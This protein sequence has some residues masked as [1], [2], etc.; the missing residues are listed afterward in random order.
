MLHRWLS[1]SLA[2]VVVAVTG[3]ACGSTSPPVTS[4]S[5]LPSAPAARAIPTDPAQ[6]S[7]TDR[8]GFPEY[9][10]GVGDKLSLTLRDVQVVTEEVAVRPDGNISFRMLENVRAAGRTP[11]ELDDDL[12]SQL[13]RFVRAPK[14]DVEVIDY[15]SKI[16]SILGAI[17][18]L[19]RAPIKS[20]QGRYPLKGRTTVLDMI[21]EAGGTTPDA[22]LERVQLIR[23]EGS[24]RLDLRSVLSSG[25]QR[26]NV[27][28]QGG[29][30]LIVPGTSLRSKKVIVLGEVARPNVYMFSDDARLMEALSQAG[31]FAESALR[32]D[33]RLIRVVEGEARMYS[34]NVE[35]L[36]NHGDYRQNVALENDDILFVPRSFIG[37][38]NDVITKIEPLLNILLLPAT[39]RD[40][41]TTGGGLRLDTGDP[42]ASSS[43]FTRTLPGTAKPADDGEGREE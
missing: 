16:V 14:I 27:V 8:G 5:E 36:A 9:L 19:E 6:T 22:Q 43:N 4:V 35:R 29:D 40:L 39:Y 32:N 25:E 11:T 24:Y 7:Y 3:I 21:L 23:G 1:A 42:P 17:E 28:L 41:Y 31:G 20:G 13:S 30:I 2:L 10:I 38:V 26:D 15:R 33:V 37:D 18:Q 12:T 34:I